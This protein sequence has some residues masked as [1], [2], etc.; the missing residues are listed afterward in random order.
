MKKSLILFISFAIVIGLGFVIW[1]VQHSRATSE[2]LESEI[3]KDLTAE[4]I[5]T[6][7]KSEA[8]ADR[9][10]I[11]AMKDDAEKRK[12]FVKGLNEFLSIA[13]QARR[14]GFAE[15]KNFKLNLA[16]KKNILL[17]DLY[18]MKLSE[19]KDRLYVVPQEEIEQVWKDSK[20][21]KLFEKDMQA[22]R[23]I[24]I[25]DAKAK[26][27]NGNIPKLKGEVLEKAR[28]KWARTIILSEMAKKDSG[29]INQ[30]AIPLRFKIL[31]AGILAQ[32]Y[33]REHWAKEIKPTQSEIKTYL[34]ERPK[35]DVKKKLEKAE[36]VL[37]KAK[38]GE[39]FEKL[40]KEYSEDRASKNR[41]GEYKDIGTNVVWREVEEVALK[42][43]KGEISD[44]II[45]SNLGYH[46][47]KLVDKNIPK[48][49]DK[50]A[51]KFTIKHIVLQKQFEEPGNRLPGIPPPFL[52]PEEIAHAEIQ[53]A[54][55]ENFIKTI[56]E[57]NPISL[58]EDF[59]VDLPKLKQAKKDVSKSE[60]KEKTNNSK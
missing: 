35:Y 59:T 4:E 16:Y 7:L 17:A 39:D 29:F 33:L 56:I 49:G 26:G 40:A 37:A 44:S 19:G 53:K 60:T 31:E 57:Q 24:R 9:S 50:N 1:Q 10:S 48:N 55:R 43:K 45:E 18:L 13:A 52:K 22:L 15:N 28:S 38:K 6:V 27:K 54:K 32:D 12:A 21:E 8:K 42:L 2:K 3:L 47:V 5:T 36:M 41:G 46:I 20:N 58:P 51:L 14:E 25:A 23:E 30:P 11:S 34:I